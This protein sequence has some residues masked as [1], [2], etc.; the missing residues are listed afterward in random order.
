MGRTRA[1]GWKIIKFRVTQS[2]VHH[3]ITA[4]YQEPTKHSLGPIYHTFSHIYIESTD[5]SHHT[6]NVAAGDLWT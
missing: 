2:S 4:V 3:T 5:P 1:D 6:E